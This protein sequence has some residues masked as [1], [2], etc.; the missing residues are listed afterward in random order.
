VTGAAGFIGHRLVA[1]LVADGHDVLAVDYSAPDVPWRLDAWRSAAE[2]RLIDL[3]LY[4]AAERAVE[5]CDWVFHLAADVGGVGYLNE[6][7]DFRPFMANMRMTLNLL[8]AC[9]QE[10]VGRLFLASSSCAYPVD[11]QSHD[12][13]HLLDEDM[14]GAGWPDLMYGLEK[15]TAAKLAE[16]APFDVRAGYINSAYGP[17]LK[18]EG[19]RMKFPAAIVAKLLRARDTGEPVTM[20]GD[21][22]QRRSYIYVD[23][24]VDKIVRI[25]A[26]PYAGPVNITTVPSV[27]C[28]DVAKLAMDLLAVDVPIVHEDGPTGVMHR[29]VSNA[30]WEQVYGPD[31]TPPFEERFGQ[32]VEW[33]GSVCGSQSSVR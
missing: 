30:K 31:L 25:M 18:I 17:G 16:R 32:F 3:R 13:V 15:M 29:E 19:E 27:S 4:S 9:E 6:S 20:W 7:N 14:V 11:W 12:Y 5:G 24:V 23:D 8:E 2:R 10:N 33:M 1:R 21:G 22:T 26:E 28:L